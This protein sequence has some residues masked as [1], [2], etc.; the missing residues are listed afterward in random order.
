MVCVVYLAAVPNG[1]GEVLDSDLVVAVL[2]TICLSEP[3]AG[4]G[5]GPLDMLLPEAQVEDVLRPP[6][7]LEP[8]FDA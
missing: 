7:G 1:E 4:F 8:G 6:I 5:V 2:A 3:E